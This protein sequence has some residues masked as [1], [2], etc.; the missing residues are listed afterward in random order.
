[1]SEDLVATST[2][3]GLYASRLLRRIRREADLPAGARVLSIL[4]EHGPLGIGQLAKL[5]QCSQ[6]TMTG[7]VNALVERGWVTKDADPADARATRVTMTRE[8]AVALRTSRRA[9]G[10]LIASLLGDVEHADA[11]TAARVLRLLVESPSP[12]KGHR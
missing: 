2:E 7:T 12:E 11:A 1:M 4:D 6:P 10:E 5:D 9:I 8:G 3:I